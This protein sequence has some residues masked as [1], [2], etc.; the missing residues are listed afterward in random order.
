MQEL[1]SIIKK[2]STLFLAD[3]VELSL[4][5]L[6]SMIDSSSLQNKY[7]IGTFLSFIADKLVMHAIKTSGISSDDEYGL[8]YFEGNIKHYVYNNYH[9]DIGD[10]YDYCTKFQESKR[11]ITHESISVALTIWFNTSYRLVLA[12]E[13]MR[14]NDLYLQEMNLHHCSYVIQQDDIT[15]TVTGETFENNIILFLK[16]INNETIF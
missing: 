8:E 10:C 4:L 9:Y 14:S 16:H 2:C 15:T 11:K 6:Q 3:D 7:A 13:I 1:D 12:L 5:L